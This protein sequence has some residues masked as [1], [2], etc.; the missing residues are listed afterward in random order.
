M[1]L[2]RLIY[3]SC[4]SKSFK[5]EDIEKILTVA[6]KNNVAKSVSGLLYFNQSHFLQ[7]LEGSRSA[8]NLIYH[9]ILNDSRHEAPIILDYTEIVERDFPKWE[10]GYLPE[11]ADTRLL[12]RK[13]SG[14]DEFIPSHMSGES[15]HRLMIEM[16]K[17][18]K[19]V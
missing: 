11:T 15:C 1:Y 16:R 2:A 6:R 7:C 3:T 10:M 4:P 12:Y 8:I 17:L 19:A 9:K 14:A 18:V 5:P 13:F